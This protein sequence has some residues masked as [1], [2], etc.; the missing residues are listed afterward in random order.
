MIVLPRLIM[1]PKIIVPLIT[2]G[3][4]GGCAT[5]DNSLLDVDTK[6]SRSEETAERE[7][8]FGKDPREGA[9]N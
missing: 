9:G 7:E 6:E 3:L 8:I 4:L 1:F 5:I 2:V